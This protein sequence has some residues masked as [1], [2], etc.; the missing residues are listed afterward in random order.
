MSYVTFV[1]TVVQWVF[2]RQKEDNKTYCSV[3]QDVAVHALHSLLGVLSL[4]V[5][6]I[7]SNEDVSFL[8]IKNIRWMAEHTTLSKM[9]LLHKSESLGFPGLC[10]SVKFD[11]L[12]GSKWLK[13]LLQVLL[14]QVKVH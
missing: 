9:N 6:N 10:I 13:N 2:G 4:L 3:S 12:D 5:S 7:H 14:G 1:S 8:R 11:K